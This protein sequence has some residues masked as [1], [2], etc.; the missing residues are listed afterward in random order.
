MNYLPDR[1][2]LLL[3][4]PLMSYTPTRQENTNLFAERAHEIVEQEIDRASRH[5][6]GTF[7]AA[8][9]FASATIEAWCGW[10]DKK[11]M[12]RY[13]H[14]RPGGTELEMLNAAIRRDQERKV[15]DRPPPAGVSIG[16]QEAADSEV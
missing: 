10:A 5:A 12:Q 16:T 4:S 2:A 14:Y 9:G 7:L 6:F 1:P 13:L 15:L 11:T 3:S 8:N